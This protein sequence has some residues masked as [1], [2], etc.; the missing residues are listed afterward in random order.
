MRILLGMSGGLDSTYA[1]MKLKEEGHTV[2]GACLVMHSYTDTSLAKEAA[3]SLGI[4]LHV[5]SCEKLFS[6][7][8]IENFMNE[9]Q[10]GRTPNPC[11]V[12]NS[13]VKFKMLYD[14]AMECGFDMIATGHYARIITKECDGEVRYAVA[15]AEDSKKDQTYMLWRLPQ[16]ILSKLLFP[17]ADLRK[18]QI[19]ELAKEK[20]LVSADREESQEICFIPSNDHAEYIKTRRADALKAGNFV[21]KDGN[22]LGTHDGIV[23][24]TVGQRKGLGIAL[25]KRMFVTKIDPDTNTVTLSE[26]DETKDSLSVCD[27]VFSGSAELKV[28]ERRICEVKL[29]YLAPRVLC[30]V[31]YLGDGQGRVE[32]NT[33]VRALTPG[34]SAVFYDGARVI[35]GGFIV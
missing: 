33:P 2:E 22:V 6:D 25:G 29:R 15:N 14:Y 9:Y 26:E 20:S 19:R 10:R 28:G 12:C 31:E 16:P 8:V 35:F 4:K 13:E 5:I 18:S 11:I 7:T 24:Y 3:D 21:D 30:T 17:L 27:M 1:A 34:Q 23:K 32:L